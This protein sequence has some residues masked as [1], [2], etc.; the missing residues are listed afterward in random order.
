MLIQTKIQ[1]DKT[2]YDFIKLAHKKL[3]YRS[4]SEYVRE[5][6]DAKVREDR[7]KYRELKREAAMDMIGHA[8]YDNLFDSIGGDDFEDR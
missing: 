4:L 5:A 1:I 2:N 6:V 8:P 3:N 7:R